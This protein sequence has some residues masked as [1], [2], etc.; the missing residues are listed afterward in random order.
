MWYNK[1][2][3]ERPWC[4]VMMAEGQRT[5]V[6]RQEQL[7]RV[8]ISHITLPPDDIRASVCLTSEVKIRGMY[9]NQRQFWLQEFRV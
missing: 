3:E 2:S 7:L 4:S 1:L 8:R 5:C 6:W 9:T